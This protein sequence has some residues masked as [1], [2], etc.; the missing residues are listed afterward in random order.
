M[1]SRPGSARNKVEVGCYAITTDARA[2]WKSNNPVHAKR[3]RPRRMDRR[4]SGAAGSAPWP[5]LAADLTLAG[6]PT[7][8][9]ECA[10]MRLYRERGAR[11]L[12]REPGREGPARS[13][14]DEDALESDPIRVRREVAAV[15]PGPHGARSNP[16]SWSVSTS[17]RSRVSSSHPDTSSHWRS[18]CSPTTRSPAMV[19]AGT[20]RY[21]APW[22]FLLALLAAF[23]LAEIWQRLRRRTRLHGCGLAREVELLDA[24]CAP[25]GRELHERPLCALR[26]PWSMRAWD[27]RRERRSTSASASAFGRRNDQA[28]LAVRDDLGQA[29]NGARDHR[30]STLH[31]LERD[32]PETLPDGGH[33]DDRGVGRSP[34]CTGET[35]PRK[36]TASA[37]PSS[38]AYDLERRERAARARPRRASPPVPEHALGRARVGGRGGP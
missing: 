4:R 30:A 36:R 19:F 8:V 23:A 33:D 38:R 20:A 37:N 17:W 18:C 15:L 32:H 16:R 22:D 2:L 7:S 29:A 24:R 6:T 1:S 13:A 26:A 28:R 3:A 25:L 34:F 11:V 5:E 9:D 35:K 31:R 27:P 14:G 21:R 12:A 10:Q